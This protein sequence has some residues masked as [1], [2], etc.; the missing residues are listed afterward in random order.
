MTHCIFTNA[1]I[2]VIRLLPRRIHRF[3]GV[4]G[5]S[6]NRPLKK[7]WAQPANPSLPVKKVVNKMVWMC[8]CANGF[9]KGN[10]KVNSRDKW[11]TSIHVFVSESDNS[12]WPSS[13][14]RVTLW[15]LINATTVSVLQ[16]TVAD[17]W[18]I[19]LPRGWFVWWTEK[20]AETTQ[21]S[22]QL[23][24]NVN[25][26]MFWQTQRSWQ[27]LPS[28]VTKSNV[29]LILATCPQHI[30][31]NGWMMGT[32]SNLLKVFVKQFPK[33]HFQIAGLTSYRNRKQKQ[34]AELLNLH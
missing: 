4:K 20:I 19:L 13:S 1:V 6:S 8:Q 3:L 15:R 16:C 18:R 25:K 23:T 5:Y 10:R 17:V 34:Y 24:F 2:S 7:S 22:K 14:C 12:R 31:A 28:N 27:C 29:D 30:D 32:A 11:K 21:H 33:V 26:V 9:M